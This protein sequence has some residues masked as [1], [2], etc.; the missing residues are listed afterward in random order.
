MMPRVLNVNK[1]VIFLVFALTLGFT[2]SAAHAVVMNGKEVTAYV[3][4][5]VSHNNRTGKIVIKTENS[6][7]NWRLHNHVTVLNEGKSSERLNLEDIW[8]NTR[9]VRVWVSRDGEVERISVLG[10][11]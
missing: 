5:I 6:T 2:I 11:K 10:W 3:G 7:G 9:K 1:A 4:H 8:R